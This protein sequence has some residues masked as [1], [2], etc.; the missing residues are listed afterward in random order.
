MKKMVLLQGI[1]CILLCIF[2]IAIE[3]QCVRESAIPEKA[4]HQGK[5]VR[6]LLKNEKINESNYHG[7]VR[8]K[9]TCGK[10]ERINEVSLEEYLY[11][12]VGSEMPSSYPIEAL[13][14]QAVCARSYA[15]CR[16]KNPAAKQYDMDDTTAYQVYSPQNETEEV[17]EAVD[18]TKGE[19]LFYG[20]VPAETF[21]FSTSCGLTTDADVFR[22]KGEA[23]P[24]ISPKIVGEFE[25]DSFSDDFSKEE[26]FRKYITGDGAGAWEENE[27]WFRWSTKICLKRLNPQGIREGKAKEL[28]VKRR[29]AGGV[30]E[31]IIIS[32]GKNMVEIEGEYEV[33]CLLA[34]AAETIVLNDGTE[35][36]CTGLLPSAYFVLEESNRKDEIEVLGG[37]YGH[38]AGM[39]QNAA[40]AMAEQGMEYREILAFF[41]DG[42]ELVTIK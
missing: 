38:G 1:V 36:S 14:A 10:K 24:Y 18:A 41:F 12:V 30:V 4:E 7:K 28:K 5:K 27:K 26:V 2:C 29:G 21:F 17:R 25:R 3:G 11:G 6:V 19:V 39:S 35:T 23:Y 40:K 37:G 16:M 33:R 15:L 22:G 20:N 31:C 32:D 13:K 9:R 34:Q 8:I 42:A